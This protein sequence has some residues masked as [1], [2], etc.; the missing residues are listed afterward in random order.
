M[1]SEEH[2]MWVLFP[3]GAGNNS[4]TEQPL[5][6]LWPQ[7]PPHLAPSFLSPQ[8]HILKITPWTS[9][10]DQWLRLFFP[11]AVGLGSIPG[12]RPRY[13]M[14]QLRIRMLQGKTEDPTCSNEDPGQPNK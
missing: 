8:E 4:Y 10:V 6:A 13:H 7:P 11:N 12:H 1:S 3:E 14:P 9:L 2:R 5:G